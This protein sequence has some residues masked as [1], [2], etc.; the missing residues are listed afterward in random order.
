MGKRKKSA[1]WRGVFLR[2]LARTG[3]VRVSAGEAGV[4][5]GTAYDHR[6]KDPAFGAKWAEALE[7]AKSGASGEADSVPESDGAGNELVPR[8]SK[9]HGVQMVKAASGRWSARIERDFL[10][11]LGLT[12]CVRTSAASAGISTTTLYTRRDKYPDFAEKW[13][14]VEK[15]AKE[16]IP[17]LLTAATIASFD[18]GAEP[19]TSGRLPQVNV[20]QAIRISQIES[21]RSGAGGGGDD[22]DT[23]V[24]CKHCGR[25]VPRVATNAEVEEA[26]LEGLHAYR[27]RR[28]AEWVAEGWTEY[29]GHMIPPGWVKLSDES[30][31]F[32]RGEGY[33]GGEATALEP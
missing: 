18:P 20:D 14:Q 24:G 32:I 19:E 26:L 2:A 22:P 25:R 15:Q 30:G 10:A 31:T 3:N 9:R 5:P 23:V 4:D 6:I 21:A 1:P 29:E 8:R 28:A 17:G 27:E 12:A 16:R 7:E 13:R 33:E 11:A